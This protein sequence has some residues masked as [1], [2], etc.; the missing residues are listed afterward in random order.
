MWQPYG[1]KDEVNANDKSAV[2]GVKGAPFDIRQ[3]K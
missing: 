2:A 1:E 3:R